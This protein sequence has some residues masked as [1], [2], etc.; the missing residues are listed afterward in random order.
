MMIKKQKRRTRIKNTGQLKVIQIL[1]EPKQN[2]R[3]KF[4]RTKKDEQN[5]N[6]PNNNRSFK[7]SRTKKDEKNLNKPNKLKKLLNTKKKC[8]INFLNLAITQQI[9]VN[10]PM[11]NVSMHI[12]RPSSKK[13]KHFGN[14]KKKPNRSGSMSKRSLKV[15][16]QTTTLIRTKTIFLATLQPQIIL[17]YNLSK[18]SCT[19]RD[20]M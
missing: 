1:K 4:Q 3:G 16:N 10:A 15:C 14:Q 11:K 20:Q 2:R 17:I 8:K 5:Q 19:K 7:H 9:D 6:K 13:S 12:T 18:A